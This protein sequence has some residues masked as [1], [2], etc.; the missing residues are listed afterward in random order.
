MALSFRNLFRHRWRS[1]TAFSAVT[2]G[3]VALLL[4]GGFIEWIYSATRQGAIE[5]RLGHIQI[6]RPGYFDRGFAEPFTFLMPD[7]DPVIDSVRRLPEVEMVTPRLSFSGLISRGD[8]TIS[9]LGEGVM[10][11]TEARVSRQLTIM[12]GG[13]LASANDKGVILGEGLAG[14]L[15][16][17]VGDRVVLIAT[18]PSGGI[19]AVEVTVRGVFQTSSKSLD[20]YALRVPLPLVQRLMAVT[21]VHSWV[22]LLKDTEQTDT[23]LR[24]LQA[25]FSHD[26]SGPIEFTPWYKLADF[27]NKTVALFSRQMNVLRAMIAIIVVLS[28]SN[29]MIAN[30]FE[31]TGEIG[32][33]LALG[34]RRSRIV[35]LFVSEGLLLGILGGMLGAATGWMAALL[36]SAV[37]IPMPPAPGM[38]FGFDAKILL[39]PMLMLG[40]FLLIAATAVAASIYPA[41]RAS[42]LVIV[43]ALRHNR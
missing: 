26:G 1:L 5:S 25:T 18:K 35:S 31:R 23:V 42:R 15:G 33:L 29:T 7:N 27:Y 28:V 2:F 16:A 39:T 11:E 43:D 38:A 19:N 24:Q 10:P 37:G 13:Q 9:F 36:I 40:S 8:H 20:D 22:V 12:R 34:Y 4:A 21:G 32:T 14:N 30:I 17:H 41:W 6:T 3:V